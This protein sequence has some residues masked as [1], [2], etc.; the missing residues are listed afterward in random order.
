MSFKNV[1][2]IAGAIMANSSF[3]NFPLFWRPLSC[4]FLMKSNCKE[5]SLHNLMSSLCPEKVEGADLLVSSIFMVANI[6]SAFCPHLQFTKF[7]R[8]RP[9]CCSKKK[10]IKLIQMNVE[11]SPRT[12]GPQYLNS[13]RTEC[14]IAIKII[15]ELQLSQKLLIP[16]SVSV[17]EFFKLK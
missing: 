6:S 2:F 15:W 11:S 3:P 7:P 13:N 5:N 8:R 1:P 9:L 17:Y 14:K 16:S 4:S 10:S 12:S